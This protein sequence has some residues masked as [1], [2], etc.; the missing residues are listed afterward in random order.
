[1]EQALT[2]KASI[3]F[4]EITKYGVFFVLFYILNIA[5]IQG[6]ISLFGFGLFF[7]LSFHKQKVY[8]LVPLYILSCYLSDFTLTTL[9]SSIVTSAVVLVATL[10]HYKT[11]KR[12]HYLLLGFYALLSQAYFVYLNSSSPESLLQA[13]IIT[14]L[15]ILFFFACYHIIKAIMTRG[16][17][18][19]LTIDE[20]ICAGILLIAISL[21]FS[22]IVIFE[23]QF[24]RI[25]AVFVI[26]LATYIYPFSS[27]ILIANI[28]GLGTLLYQGD[29]SYLVT[30]SLFAFSAVSFKHN[31][32]VIPILA[33]LF[34]DI[35]LGLYFNVTVDYNFYRVA[36]ILLG[37]ILFYSIPTT[38]LNILKSVL[39]GEESKTAIRNIVNRSR[40]G[41]CRRMYEISGVFSEM[42]HVF[43]SM[44][45]GVLPKEEAKDMLTQE[46]IDKVCG[47]CPEKHKCLRAFQNDTVTIIQDIINA[48]FE[49]GKATILDVPPHLSTRC[50]RVNTI[51]ISINQLILSYK[52][53]ATMINNLDTSRVLIA[54]QLNGVGKII[55]SLA[56]ET[57]RNVTFDVNKESALMEELTYENIVC[58][59]CVIYEQNSE[60][61]CVTLI[62]RS[63][64]IKEKLI[65][66]IVSKICGG[67]MAI[68]SSENSSYAGFEVL[69]L[70]TAPKYNVVFGSSGLTKSGNKVSGDTYS[71]IKIGDDK[72]MF[73]ICDGMGS[74]KKAEETSNLAIS[75]IE[76]FYKAGFDND[77]IL[78]SVNKLLSLGQ[79]EVFTALDICVV[80]LRKSIADFIKVGSPEGY[81]K[82]KENTETIKTGSLP[83]GILEEMQPAI[84]KKVLSSQDMIILFSDGVID[85]FLSRESF[86]T[87]LN[88]ISTINPQTFAET[89]LDKV[90]ENYNNEPKDDCT[91]IVARVFP[92]V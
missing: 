36:E 24:I 61:S 26:L 35:L 87:F 7:S 79:E 72:F 3:N 60:I 76:N 17:L 91:V 77:I 92:C 21:G 45:R 37:S 81:I 32:R 56:E 65:E 80:D 67:K 43:K 6:N 2:K 68:V 83:L 84:S 16:I 15:G 8:Y 82:N 86:K 59:E 55:R 73:A 18:F 23:T 74:G 14:L 11:N 54:E 29:F 44:V 63:K 64:D 52:Q 1:M 66:K 78:T 10:L 62:V 69:T 70:K 19:K 53:Y 30:F 50:S 34:T 75:L 31:N 58:T 41:L 51:L 4:L 12:P 89:I 38:K 25:F 57:R 20:L 9:T 46:I 5:S 88:S 40:D 27:S 39:G 48:G 42:D 28:I 22:N 47:D 85:S 33:I 49:R 13:I 71:F 90:L